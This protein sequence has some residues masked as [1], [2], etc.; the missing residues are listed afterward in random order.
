MTDEQS[1]EFTPI[2]R[3]GDHRPMR[4]GIRPADLN[5]S[6]FGGDP[7]SPVFAVLREAAEH[8][9]SPFEPAEVTDEEIEDKATAIFGEEITDSFDEIDGVNRGG[10]PG[11]PVP[12]SPRKGCYIT[13]FEFSL[14]LPLQILPSGEGATEF[15]FVPF[16]GDRQV[17]HRKWRRSVRA[18]PESARPAA[19]WRERLA[20]AAELDVRSKRWRAALE[21]PPARVLFE[22]GHESHLFPLAFPQLHGSDWFP[23]SHRHSEHPF[24]YGELPQ[25]TETLLVLFDCVP[26]SRP[27][28]APWKHNLRFGEYRWRNDDRGRRWLDD[29]A[30]HLG[31]RREVPR[32][33]VGAV[34]WL[35]DPQAP[36]GSLGAA[37]LIPLPRQLQPA[38]DHL[39]Q[40]TELWESTLR[41]LLAREIKDACRQ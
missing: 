26:T 8:F 35:T 19:A 22:G 11:S 37:A 29:V 3:S 17:T 7:H 31:E 27:T 2:S 13:S 20:A 4:F 1:P 16:L 21:Q 33:E 9:S 15:W 38:R 32:G 36:A 24:P 41:H 18:W 12:H 6:D 25:A 28:T 5:P 23:C 39:Q 10:E 40:L 14:R 30:E 34:L